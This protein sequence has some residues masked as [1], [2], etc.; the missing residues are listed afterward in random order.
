VTSRRIPS[1]VPEVDC[2]IAENKIHIIAVGF[3]VSLSFLNHNDVYAWDSKG[4]E[5]VGGIADQLLTR[6]TASRVEKL[7]GSDI[8]TLR[9]ASVWADC[10]KEVKPNQDGFHYQRDPRYHSP[11]CD[12]FETSEEIA[13][14]ED[15]VSRNWMQNCGA[16]TGEEPCHK[17]YHYADV[18]I[19]HDH[20]DRAY[21]GTSD[22]DIVGVINASIDVLEG[23]ASLSPFNIKDKKEALL[24]L[25][26]FVGDIHQPLHVV[27]I[28]INGHNHAFDPDISGSD[29]SKSTETHGGNLIEVGTTNLHAEWDHVSRGVSVDKLLANAKSQ[30]ITEGVVKSWSNKWASEAVV[31]AK[32]AFS[33]IEMTHDGA[34]KAGNW[35]VQFSDRPTYLKSKDA[36]QEEQLSKAGARLAQLLNLIANRSNVQTQELSINESSIVNREMGR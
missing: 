2:P 23:K 14:M 1:R 33:G 18:A 25:S 35:T 26:H 12:V 34:V 9:V 7:L 6:Q 8:K 20:Y 36:L 21:V 4:H 15:Y 11:S 31:Q 24:L 32:K 22:H 13:R 3:F 16:G 30:P 5:V 27:S 17:Q 19:Q 10:A 28:Y 29:R